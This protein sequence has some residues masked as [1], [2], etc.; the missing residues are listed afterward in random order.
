[1][2]LRFF[3]RDELAADAARQVRALATDV[4]GLR[5]E[6]ARLL[7][8][9]ASLHAAL[10]TVEAENAGLRATNAALEAEVQTLTA[11]LN[12]TSANSSRPPSADPPHASFPPRRPPSG[13]NAGGQGGH[14]AHQRLLLPVAEVD[15]VIGHWPTVCPHCQA[16]LPTDAAGP[17]P[18]RHQVSELPPVPVRVVEHQLHR[19]RCLQCGQSTRATLPPAV[20]TGAFGPRLAATVAVLAGRY[21]LSRREVTD[22]CETL[23]GVPIA[24]G[25]VDTLCQDVAAA[26][27]EPVAELTAAL[28][29]APVVHADETGWRQAGKPRTLW[30]VVTTLMTVFAVAATRGS[31]VIKGLLGEDFAGRLV[32]DRWSGYTWVA[33]VQRQVCWAHLTRDFQALVDWGGDGKPVGLAALA[34]IDELF[35][36]WHQARDD[37][38]G[39]ATL[40][41]AMA[42]IQARFKTLLAEGT[43][44]PAGKTRGLCRNLLKLW[45]ALW[46]FVTV[47]GVEPTNNA[48]E[49]AIRPAVLWR[50]GSF[51]CQSDDG[52][53]FVE[54][55]LT[56]A[57][58]CR[59]QERSLLD[60]LT[61][62]C[63]AAQ[64]HHPI[65]SL[66]PGSQPTRVAYPSLAP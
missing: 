33:V 40:I 47:P 10:I 21:R 59:Q 29:A 52:A 48:A 11:R 61:A 9:V 66:L 7:A 44:N 54:R 62:V 28:P 49:Q 57:A 46:T 39:R 51:G 35:G 32:S 30:V 53:H 17:D 63:V 13:R 25:S 34:V 31:C 4:A 50:K 6:V 15:E 14:A 41:A 37:P 12:Q 19:V 24:V 3:H 36:A 22:V 45:P 60:Y 27:A 8:E 55:M 2:K 1:M 5:V 38:A 65:P 26:L 64:T 18:V 58:T 16:A 56:V 23:F 20:P 42:P 43:T